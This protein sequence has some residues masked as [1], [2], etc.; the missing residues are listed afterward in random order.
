MHHS[1]NSNR[2]L[3]LITRDGSIVMEVLSEE[4]KHAKL[5][6]ARVLDILPCNK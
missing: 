2:S 6:S 1:K 3:T 4:S 5:C